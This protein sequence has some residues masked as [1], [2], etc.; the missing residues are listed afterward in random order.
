MV[1][2]MTREHRPVAGLCLW[3]NRPLIFRVP[4]TSFRQLRVEIN[5]ISLSKVCFV[6]SRMPRLPNRPISE[7]G[8]GLLLVKWLP[9]YDLSVLGRGSRRWRPRRCCVLV[10][11]F[12]S[13][14][15]IWIYQT[16]GNCG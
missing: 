16:M 9:V 4:F 3:R 2:T 14:M 15:W 6:A 1:M 8:R 5:T 13:F 7:T 10:L 11:V 12:I